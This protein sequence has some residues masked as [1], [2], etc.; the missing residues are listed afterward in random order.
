MANDGMHVGRVILQV[1]D[2]RRS[3][4]FYEDVI[5]FARR[6]ELRVGGRPAALLAAHGGPGDQGSNGPILLELREKPGVRAVPRRGL[7][8]LYHFALLLPDRPSLAMFV[9]HLR[10]SGTPAAAADHGFSEALY[11][12]DPDGLQ[13]EVYR[14]RPRETWELRDGEYVAVTDPLD[15]TDL[16]RTADARGWIGVPAGSIIGHVHH[17]VGDL[18]DADRFYHRGLGLSRSITTL[19]GAL[20][21]AAGGYHHHVGLNTWIAPAPTASADD[22][23]LV[24]WEL[25][26][27]DRPAV[28]ATIARLGAE[29]FATDEDEGVTRAVDPWSIAVRLVLEDRDP[30]LLRP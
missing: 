15:F 26:L 8:G 2:L 24:A 13:V 5:G 18:D 30:A 3:L 23:R 1:S 11:L 20:F 17:Y 28:D 10:Q 29:G 7:L 6:D 25:V 27:P 21:V 14:D 22:A 19:P 9:R 12:V 4:L 16:L